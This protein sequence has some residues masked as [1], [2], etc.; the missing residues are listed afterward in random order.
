MLTA[1]FL[2]FFNPASAL[3]FYNPWTQAKVLNPGQSHWS[4]DTTFESSRQKSNYPNTQVSNTWGDLINNAK[5]SQEIASLNAQRTAAGKN[6]DDVAGVTQYELYQEITT[7]NFSW[8]YGIY[9]RWM[10]GVNA[11][12]LM[13]RQSIEAKSSGPAG[14][15]VESSSKQ[16]LNE[17]GVNAN[18]TEY[19]EQRMGDVSLLSQVQLA[20]LSKW[21]FAFQ[22]RI[23]LPTSSQPDERNLF[24]TRAGNGQPNFGGRLLGSWQI[25]TSTQINTS[26]GYLWQVTDQ[27]RIR[28]PNINGDVTGEIE[29]GVSR[30]LGDIYDAQ[31]EGVWRTG[32]FSWVSSYRV[33]H[34]EADRYQGSFVE[35]AR[36]REL[37]ANSAWDRQLVSLGA[38]YYIGNQLR[39]GVRDAYSILVAG[40]WP[41]A[42]QS[43]LWSLDLR[44]MF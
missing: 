20:T 43:P 18:R 17:I 24:M 27:V 31:V 39:G 6:I 38:L 41:L 44:M 1:L 15:D 2:F 28:L 36:Y 5:D 42:E 25:S 12:V 4:V 10:I 40:H 33:L 22:Q 7:M 13:T 23:G 19:N 8:S 35:Q 26:I 37:G 3:S 11:P 32:A 30:D 16:Y 29:S 9:R 14:V 34:K 21:T